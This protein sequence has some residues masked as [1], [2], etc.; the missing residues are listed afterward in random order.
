MRLGE[1]QS[2]SE[3]GAIQ[4]SRCILRATFASKLY[5]RS[6][7]RIFS[8]RNCNPF[9]AS[10]RS[11]RSKEIELEFL[12]K[13]SMLFKQTIDFGS[14]LYNENN[15]MGEQVYKNFE[16]RESLTLPP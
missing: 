16:V 10:L 8:N 12:G 15:G 7:Q 9:R 11:S 14:E 4:T 13:D 6:A 2:S 3:E 1:N 5:T